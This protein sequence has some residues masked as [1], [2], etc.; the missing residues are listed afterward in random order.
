MKKLNIEH[1]IKFKTKDGEK[2]LST[3]WNDK[4][5]KLYAE[6]KCIKIKSF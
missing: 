5:K 1:F 6:E 2:L 4:L 3:Y